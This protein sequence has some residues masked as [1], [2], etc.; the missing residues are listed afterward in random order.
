M[1]LEQQLNVVEMSFG[2]EESTVAGRC[3]EIETLKQFLL[4]LRKDPLISILQPK[5]VTKEFFN[6]PD[7]DET[8]LDT[9][10]Y[11]LTCD[12]FDSLLDPFMVL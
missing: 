7:M 1:T 9:K 11:Q 6:I 4:K 10:V 5:T 2:S 8:D 12:N 3:S